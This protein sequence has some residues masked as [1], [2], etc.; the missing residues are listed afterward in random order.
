MR[1]RWTKSIHFSLFCCFFSL[2]VAQQNDYHSYLHNSRDSMSRLS[3]FRLVSS[4][5]TH[6][7][8]K[9]YLISEQALFVHQI[10]WRRARARVS[11]SMSL[12]DTQHSTTRH[13]VIRRKS[14]YRR[15]YHNRSANIQKGY[16]LA[17][18]RKI[19][20][21]D[22]NIVTDC[23]V[24]CSHDTTVFG[25]LCTVYIYVDCDRP[26]CRHWSPPLIPCAQM[27]MSLKIILITGSLF[28][29]L[30]DVE[31][32]ARGHHHRCRLLGS[33]WWQRQLFAINNIHIYFPVSDGSTSQSQNAYAIK[34]CVVWL[35][36][37]VCVLFWYCWQTILGWSSAIHQ[38]KLWWM[39]CIIC[40]ILYMYGRWPSLWC[41]SI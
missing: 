28:S 25:K 2:G 19:V 39:I 27:R 29:P 30:R 1:R 15:S 17:Y 34:M 24:S 38:Q 12:W 40:I 32:R 36:V 13:F 41:A 5:Y 3:N 8:L 20:A 31:N 21:A 22:I 10:L 26:I 23:C 6:T 37:C 11:S 35:C 4:I 16:N 7:T 33:H 14:N 9:C 18:H